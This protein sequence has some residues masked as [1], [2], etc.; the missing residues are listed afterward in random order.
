MKHVCRR[1]NGVALLW[2]IIVIEQIFVDTLRCHWVSAIEVS[3]EPIASEAS[4]L[5]ARYE[6]ISSSVSE[7]IVSETSCVRVYCE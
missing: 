3:F 2:D 1:A 7:L 6:P 5:Q 4:R